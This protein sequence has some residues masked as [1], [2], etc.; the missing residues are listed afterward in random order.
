MGKQNAL[1]FAIEIQK[2]IEFC[3]KINSKIITEYPHISDFTLH[4]PMIYRMEH[5]HFLNF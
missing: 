3:D 4:F 2:R 5:K 1:G